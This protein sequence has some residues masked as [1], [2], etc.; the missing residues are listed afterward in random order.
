M[1]TTVTIPASTTNGEHTVVLFGQDPTGADFN[2]QATITVTGGTDGGGTGG[3]GTDTGGGTDTT[4]GGTLAATG[5]SDAWI[6][7]IAGLVALQAGLVVAVRSRR[8]LVGVAG[9]S[10]GRHRLSV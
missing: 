8:A 5:V 6:A 10:A 9:P 2:L 4:G 1:N 7:A 3:N